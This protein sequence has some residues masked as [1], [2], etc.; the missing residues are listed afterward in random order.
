MNETA[1]VKS[2]LQYLHIQ[3]GIFAWRNNV[4]AV[5]LESAKG[6]RFVRFGFSGMSDIMVVCRGGR[7]LAIEAKVGRNKQTFDQ[8]VFQDMI[9]H[10]GGVYIVAYSIEDVQGALKAYNL[11]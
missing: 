7:F 5:K 2:I 11:I 10:V 8:K 9:E 4:G 6:D 1:L 3:K